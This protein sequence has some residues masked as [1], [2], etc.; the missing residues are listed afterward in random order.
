M[1]QKRF[2]L[3]QLLLAVALTAAVVLAAGALAVNYLLCGAGG[4]S[5]VEAWHLINTRFVGEYDQ[6]AVIDGALEGMVNALG[7]R[8][9]YTLTAEELAAIRSV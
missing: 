2:S 3:F 8:W 5:L 1:R 4:R 9:S 6:E 7:D